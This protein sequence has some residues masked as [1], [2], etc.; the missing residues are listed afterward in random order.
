M[1]S[2]EFKVIPNIKIRPIGEY[3]FVWNRIDI[4]VEE[5]IYQDIGF[6]RPYPGDCPY[7]RKPILSA[8]LHEQTGHSHHFIK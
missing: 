3:D 1:S 8:F 4:G 5:V 2:T 6:G 7:A